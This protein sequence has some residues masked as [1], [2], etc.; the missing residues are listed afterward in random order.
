MAEASS[1]D[2]ALFDEQLSVWRQGDV[3][4]PDEFV[5]LHLA[6]L[7]QPLT[8]EA[9][10]L[11]LEVDPGLHGVP[12][13]VEGVVVLTQTCDIV[14]SCSD[15]PFVE[16]APLVALPQDLLEDVRN[17]RR[18]AYAWVPSISAKRGLVAHLDRVMTVEKAVVAAWERVQGCRNDQEARDFALALARKRTRTAF[19]TDFNEAA[20][21][22][23]QR[24]KGKHGKAS[25]E[26]RMLNALREIRV[27][28]AP[29]WDA[30]AVMIFLWF[31]KTED[32]ADLQ[33]AWADQLRAWVDLV[34]WTNR[35]KCE[36]FVV[37]SL[38]DLTAQDY[39]ESDPLDLDHLSVG[40]N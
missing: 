30:P 20:N 7:R 11:A 31:I 9:R 25:L 38:S 3:A 19:P 22:L 33:E 35:F 12:S 40:G 6:D 2:F 8:P 23:Q 32:P 10:Q 37:C 24:I 28:A 14:R 26:G 29:S 34:D 4:L 27:R 18:P 15:R 16:I 5:F 17:N 39:V 36:G 13:E 1:Q 21:G